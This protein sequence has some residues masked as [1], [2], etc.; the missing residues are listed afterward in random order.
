MAV[1]SSQQGHIANVRAKGCRIRII[2]VA[3]TV[4]SVFCP[5]IAAAA[6]QSW[7]HVLMVVT[8]THLQMKHIA[9]AL[10]IG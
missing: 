8:I 1:S 5:S 3:T 7:S 9:N 6:A 10:V 4:I 2:A